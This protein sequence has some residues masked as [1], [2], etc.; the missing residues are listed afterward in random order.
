[1]GSFACQIFEEFMLLFSSPLIDYFLQNPDVSRMVIPVT[2][3]AA[4]PLCR[5]RTNTQQA[6]RP[7]G[8]DG[9]SVYVA[10]VIQ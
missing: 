7:L 8:Q 4:I 10:T 2:V 5:F 1:M 9:Q 6:K 3:L